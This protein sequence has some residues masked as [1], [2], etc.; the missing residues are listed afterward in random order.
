VRSSALCPAL[1]KLLTYPFTVLYALRIPFEMVL[2]MEFHTDV[3]ALLIPFQTLVIVDFMAFT[4]LEMALLIPLNTEEAVDFRPFQILLTFAFAEFHAVLMNCVTAE[5]AEEIPDLMEFQA[6]AAALFSEFQSG[7]RKALI[8]LQFMMM[9]AAKMTTA[10]MI[11]VKGLVI[12]ATRKRLN[13][14]ISPRKPATSIRRAPL[15]NVEM[16]VPIVR[17]M[18]PAFERVPVN[19]VNPPINPAMGPMTIWNTPINWKRTT[20]TMPTAG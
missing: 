20:N 16:A 12:I 13:T 7:R 19:V 9:I 3:V 5:T 4:A 18:G 14:L 6:F 8:L 17:K 15:A 11:A 2:L 10:V 1:R